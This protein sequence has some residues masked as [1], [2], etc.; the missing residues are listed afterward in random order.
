MGVIG[1]MRARRVANISDGAP[2]LAHRGRI[3][4]PWGFRKRKQTIAG[5]HESRVHINELR[6]KNKLSIGDQLVGA[7]TGSQMVG[8]LYSMARNTEPSDE[9]DMNRV[10]TGTDN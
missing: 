3:N 1:V 4:P 6:G 10:E 2:S 7:Q 8:G 9:E 5:A